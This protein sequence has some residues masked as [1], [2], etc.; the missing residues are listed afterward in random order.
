MRPPIDPD[1]AYRQIMF[2]DPATMAES[3]PVFW[4]GIV[5]LYGFLFGMAAVGLP[6]LFMALAR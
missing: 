5:F 4:N 2:D 3:D 1:K 6:A